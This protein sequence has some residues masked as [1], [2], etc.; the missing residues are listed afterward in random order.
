MTQIRPIALLWLE[1][2]TLIGQGSSRSIMEASLSASRMQAGQGS[3]HASCAMGKP[4]QGR[5]WGFIDTRPATLL[6]LLGEQVITCV[7]GHC[8]RRI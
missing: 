3:S 8:Q 7:D 6:L 4:K 5:A 2:T 1:E